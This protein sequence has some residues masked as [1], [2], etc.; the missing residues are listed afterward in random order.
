MRFIFCVVLGFCLLIA[1]S[2]ARHLFLPEWLVPQGLLVCAVFLAFYE[3]SFLGALIAFILGLLLDLSSGV[4]VGPWAGAYV[5]VYS[6]FAF[7]S[8]RLFVESRLVAMTVVAIAT[9]LAGFVFISLAFEYQEV[10]ADDWLML[11]GQALTSSLI[12]PVVF[13]A[14]KSVWRR[15]DKALARRGA[16]ISP[17]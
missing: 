10:T 2:C 16:V 3:F 11:G 8:R 4:L 9:L 5:V 13:R 1:Q 17:V 14:L 12:T 6:I 7:L 15:Q